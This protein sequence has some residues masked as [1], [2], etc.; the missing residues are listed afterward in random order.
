MNGRKRD[1]NAP[2]VLTRNQEIA[3]LKE[4]AR[5]FKFGFILKGRE[6]EVVCIHCDYRSLKFIMD[7]V[8]TRPDFV[9]WFPSRETIEDRADKLYRER[10]TRHRVRGDGL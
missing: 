10:L 4:E 3:A 5:P 6:M 9:R 1:P 2:P 7:S 8:E